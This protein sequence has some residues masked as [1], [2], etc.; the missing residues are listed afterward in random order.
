MGKSAW[1]IELG[2]SSV[3]AVKLSEDRGSVTLDSISIV[4]LS[5]YGLGGGTGLNLL[6]WPQIDFAKFG[7]VESK[8]LSRIKKISGANLAR[9][10]VLIP[11]VTQH[12]EADITEMEAF[13][14]KLGEENKDL[15]V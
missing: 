11:H 5:D 7:P 14:K 8:P 6:P 12:D 10:W 3:K 4:S 13:R 9:N 1:G 2:T 15:K